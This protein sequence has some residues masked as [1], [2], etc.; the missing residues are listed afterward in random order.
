MTE[1][2][3][4]LSEGLQE[5]ARLIK[6]AEGEITP[7]IEE[8]LDELTPSWT[9]KVEACCHVLDELRARFDTLDAHAKRLTDA[10]R[11][12]K[13]SAD[14]L[15]EYM[16]LQHI[17]ADKTRTT[18]DTH[19]VTVQR[20]GVPTVVINDWDS[21]PSELR[22]VKESP[23]TAAIRALIEGGEE[24]AGASLEYGN[25]LRTRLGAASKEK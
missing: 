11:S 20:N 8:R 7:E 12:L 14:G 24:V 16:R 5:V 10:K 25:H 19:I 2:L 22:K 17:A 1:T 15:R 21:I 9:A 13:R 6:E 3:W 18:T 4:E 23:D